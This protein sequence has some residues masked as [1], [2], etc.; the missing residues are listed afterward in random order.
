LMLPF[1]VGGDKKAT[2]LYG[3]FSDTINRLLEVSR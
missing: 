1:T 3:L 2:D